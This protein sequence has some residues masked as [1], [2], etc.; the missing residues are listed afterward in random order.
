[1]S[2]GLSH[3]A[4]LTS[5]THAF[6]CWSTSVCRRQKVSK[7]STPI[8][9]KISLPVYK[10][11]PR[12]PSPNHS[13]QYGNSISEPLAR[14]KAMLSHFEDTKW[15]S[16][17]VHT[18]K[19]GLVLLRGT[20][21]LQM[22]RGIFGPPDRCERLYDTQRLDA[23]GNSEFRRRGKVRTSLVSRASHQPDHCKGALRHRG[24]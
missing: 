2:A 19:V 24:G 21:P 9:L 10:S 12:T 17:E 18:N 7:T 15:D 23:Y 11:L 4:S 22:D 20:G 14:C 8:T 16:I 13:S 6:T 3:R 5:A 1:M